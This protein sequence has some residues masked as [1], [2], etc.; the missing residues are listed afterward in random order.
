MY[1]QYSHNFSQIFTCSSQK[2]ISIFR[3]ICDVTRELCGDYKWTVGALK[4]IHEGSEAFLITILEYG[5]LAAIHGG[6]VTILPRDIQLM[7]KIKKVTAAYKS[8]D[9]L[10]GPKAQER[11]EAQKGKND[12][13]NPEWPGSWGS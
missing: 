6:H 5:N 3:V 11:R 12:I 2:F 4:A 8:D 7:M 9:P 10:T 1:M 13:S